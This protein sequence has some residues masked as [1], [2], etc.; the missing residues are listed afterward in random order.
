MSALVV[1]VLVL[2]YPLGYRVVSCAWLYARCSLLSSCLVPSRRT[3][4]TKYRRVC[5]PSFSV[6][7]LPRP[8]A[9]LPHRPQTWSFGLKASTS[10][11]AVQLFVVSLTFTFLDLLYTGTPT[12]ARTQCAIADCTTPRAGASRAG[13]ASSNSNGA[14]TTTYASCCRTSCSFDARAAAQCPRRARFRHGNNNTLELPILA[15]RKLRSRGLPTCQY[16]LTCTFCQHARLL[17]TRTRVQDL[18]RIC[19]IWGLSITGYP[20]PLWSLFALC[21]RFKDSLATRTLASGKEQGRVGD[22]LTPRARMQPHAAPRASSRA[23]R[24]GRG[25]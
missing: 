2:V 10:T 18:S 8:S 20:G 22:P 6:C 23:G 19:H 3:E 9:R 14:S 21:L 11:R 4:S 25:R 24:V 7:P 16:L 17:Y 15:S 5:A 12:G 1:L 13:P